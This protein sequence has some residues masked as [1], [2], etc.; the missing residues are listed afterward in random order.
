MNITSSTLLIRVALV[1]AVLLVLH[2]L[3]YVFSPEES[4]SYLREIKNSHILA[5]PNKNWSFYGSNDIHNKHDD[6]NRVYN[7]TL[8]FEKVFV[9]SLPERTDK[10]DAITLMCAV[11]NITF[12]WSDGVKMDE[13]VSKAIPYG[14]HMENVHDNFVSNWRTHMNAVHQ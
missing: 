8:G 12:E 5:N 9:I 1:A 2:T 7:D 3:F 4:F 11:S 13:M 10:R 14:I 6:I